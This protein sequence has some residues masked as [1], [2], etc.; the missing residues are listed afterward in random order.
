[1]MFRTRFVVWL[2]VSLGG[3]VLYR[4]TLWEISSGCGLVFGE[5]SNAR[6]TSDPVSADELRQLEDSAMLARALVYLDAHPVK[7]EMVDRR[8]R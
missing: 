2:V 6:A 8:L 7:P 3:V 1:M 4:H 5:V